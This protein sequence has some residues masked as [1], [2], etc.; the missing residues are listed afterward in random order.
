MRATGATTPDTYDFAVDFGRHNGCCNG[1]RHCPP[2]QSER[3][4]CFTERCQLKWP[5]TTRNMS[6]TYRVTSLHFSRVFILRLMSVKMGVSRKSYL[7][8]SR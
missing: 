7:Y 3:V 8:E 2:L 5:T 6:A 4:R 1:R